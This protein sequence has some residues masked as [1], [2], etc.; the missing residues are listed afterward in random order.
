MNVI[1]LLAAVMVFGGAVAMVFGT[2]AFTAINADRASSVDVASDQNALVGLDIADPVTPTS[3]AELVTVSNNFD[4]P[5]T[6]TVT[7]TS[8]TDSGVSLQDTQKTIPEGES[9]TFNVNVDPLQQPRLIEFQVQSSSDG[10][11]AVSLTRTASVA[12]VGVC[13]DETRVIDEDVNGDIDSEK[14]VE[15]SSNVQVKGD[16]DAEGCVILNDESHIKGDTNAGSRVEAGEKAKI[17][18]DVDAGDG[19]EIGTKGEIKGDLDAGGSVDL[20][21]E[22]GIKGDLSTGGSLSMAKK[23]QVKGDADVGGSTALGEKAQIE[24]DLD[25]GGNVNLGTD[26][27]AKGDLSA[28]GD[29]TLG[30]DADVEGDVGLTKDVTLEMGPDSEI[31][32]NVEA[33]DPASIELI[34]SSG[35][36]ID[37]EPCEDYTVE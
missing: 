13:G 33:D 21:T 31:K 6:V 1:K 29:L 5:M 26:A 3:G 27:K 4:E 10:A 37:G 25:A 20:D 17:G 18:G 15:L 24:S 19:V 14:N 34:C 36:R 28:G 32:G 2:G 9:E 30:D 22:A 23:A 12:S 35:A 11:S 16:V 7:L 8:N